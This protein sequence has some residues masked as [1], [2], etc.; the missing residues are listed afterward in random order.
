MDKKRQILSASFEV[1]FS[2]SLTAM[3]KKRQILSAS[4]EV[5]FQQVFNNCCE[6]E[7]A[8]FIG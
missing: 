3:D 5:L 4:F 7:D 8:D 2:R 1:L 6:Q